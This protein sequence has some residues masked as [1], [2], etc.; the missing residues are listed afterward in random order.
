[1]TLKKSI[2]FSKEWS[3]LKDDFFLTV[4]WRDAKYVYNSI[5]PV[6]IKGKNRFYGQIVFTLNVKLRDLLYEQFTYYDADCDV[7]HYYSMLKRWYS[8]KPDWKE[9]N[10]IVQIVGIRKTKNII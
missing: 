2:K 3:K 1:M 6:I 10:S 7:K 4:R 5:I 8:R 9:K